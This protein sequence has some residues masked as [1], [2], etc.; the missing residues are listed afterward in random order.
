MLARAAGNCRREFLIELLKL[1]L[2]LRCLLK[3][4]EVTSGIIIVI[5]F[6]GNG[7]I[8]VMA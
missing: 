7:G 1:S 6:V 2:S 5:R 4:R 3:S 8:I